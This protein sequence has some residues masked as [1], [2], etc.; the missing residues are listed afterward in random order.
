MKRLIRK[1]RVNNKLLNLAILVLILNALLL[2]YFILK[3]AN[4]DPD[5]LSFNKIPIVSPTSAPTPVVVVADSERDVLKFPGRKATGLDKSAYSALVQ[6]YAKESDYLDIGKCNPTPLV[7]KVKVGNTIKLRN[8]DTSDHTLSLSSQKGFLVSAGETREIK[9]D[10]FPN[11]QGIY[12][13]GCDASPKSV[14][15]FLAV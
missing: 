1:T 8:Q 7:I 9:I 14:G 13:Y 15:V 2:G 12:S 3:R 6:K 10:F 5:L 4:L 11:G